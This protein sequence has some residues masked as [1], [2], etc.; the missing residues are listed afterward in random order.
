VACFVATNDQGEAPMKKALVILLLTL[1]FGLVLSPAVAQ[2]LTP[3]L[4]EARVITAINA[5]R[6]KRGLAPV[7]FNAKL[8][9]AAR[10]HSPDMA[11]RNLLTH[12]SSCGWYTGQRLRA[13]GYTY[14]DCTYY[15][16]GENI[17]RGYAGTVW[18]TPEGMVSLWM[19]SDTHRAVILTAS[20]RDI[21][22]GIRWNS[23]YTWR[24]FTADFGRRI[25]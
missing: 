12:R 6:T 9:L 24:Y 21:G 15:K 23:T 14:T 4:G 18:R 16:I 20:F 10:Y 5:E 25:Y 13:F 1:T 2:A 11:K 19:G 22:V 8:T 3:T 17:G 7:K